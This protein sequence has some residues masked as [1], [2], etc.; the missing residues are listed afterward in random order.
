MYRPKLY[1]SAKMTSVPWHQLYSCLSVVTILYSE[2]C[3]TH[4]VQVLFDWTVTVS[5]PLV[6]LCLKISC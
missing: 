3:G 5:E 4:F 2:Y 6:K 1:I